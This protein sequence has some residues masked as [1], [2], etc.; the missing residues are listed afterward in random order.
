MG[1]LSPRPVLGLL[2]YILKKLNKLRTPA[3]NH[4]HHKHNVTYAHPHFYTGLL[5][6]ILKKLNKLRI[7]PEEEQAGLDVSKH[8]GSAYVSVRASTQ[9][10]ALQQKTAGV[11]KT[12]GSSRRGSEAA[13]AHPRCT[14]PPTQNNDHGLGKGVRPGW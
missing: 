11:A 5:F 14:P 2:F 1:L 12:A 3:V 10:L 9:L 13:A 7:S 8:G 4:R 6:Y